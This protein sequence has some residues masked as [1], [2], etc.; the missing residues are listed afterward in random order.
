MDKKKVKVAA[1]V[2]ATIIAV[3]F[4]V[5]QPFAGLERAGM[6]FL[7][8][9]IWWLVMMIVDLIPSYMA[10]LIV[11]SAA[12]ATGCG[13]ANTAFS[14][15]SGSTVWLLVAAFGVSA[16]LANS[17][18]L[19]RIAIKVLALFPG[20]YAGQVIA[21]AIAS[22]IVSPLIP[23]TTG[24]A[25]ILLPLTNEIAD[26]MGYE[27]N[28]KGTV[29][30][31]HVV[32]II[33]HYGALMFMTGGIIVSMVLAAS[34][35]TQTW[36][37][38]I[39][40]FAVWGIVL[41]ALTVVYCLTIGSP[42]D[43]KKITKEELKAMETKMGPMSK[44]EI[45]ALIVLIGILVAWTTESMHGIPTHITAIVA[46]II[47]AACGLFSNK[48]LMTK[49]LWPVV[50]QV[51]AL[52][53][54]ITLLSMTGVSKWIAGFV[55]PVVA[56]FAGTPILLIIAVSLLGSALSFVMVQGSV[57]SALCVALLAGSTTVHPIIIAA[58]AYF[59]AQ[60]FVMP[61]QNTTIIAARGIYDRADH[62][63]IAH[64]G[65][66]YAICNLIALI[67][68]VPYWSMIGML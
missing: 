16:A 19:S 52:V 51:G 58:A 12:I 14:A 9:F 21:L 68:S 65:W 11:L 8:L 40:I 30:L 1:F 31:F 44:K 4:A 35:Q 46:W 33:I 64:T 41:I 53:G 67:A 50:L 43:G 60:I 29:G 26:K 22:F 27:K 10:S 55:A 63:A 45:A 28:S 13:A 17:G 5:M 18:L 20:T 66:V 36:M 6:T 59:S 48:D 2:I 25:T 62:S 42:K 57:S 24:K 37:G 34:G 23:S 15:F 7:G 39:K 47:L 54:V 38:W 56:P 3:A 32:S 61:Y 49:M